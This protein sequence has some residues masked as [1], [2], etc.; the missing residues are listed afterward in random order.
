MSEEPKTGDRLLI[1][2]IDDIQHIG[3]KFGVDIIAW[4]TDDGLDGKK[5]RRLLR[6]HLPWIIVILC[7]VHQIN[8]VVGDILWLKLPFLKAVKHAGKIIKWFNSHDVAHALL[9]AEEKFSYNSKCYALV[10][11]V[12]TRHYL[13]TMRLLKLKGAV[14]M[15]CSC[16]G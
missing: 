9:H 12:V 14:K 1:L 8:L 4:C 3:D 10:L 7:W 6:V 15:C 11:P 13:S 16:Q 5:M 2:I